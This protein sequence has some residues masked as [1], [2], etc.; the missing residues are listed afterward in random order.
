MIRHTELQDGV[1]IELIQV[2]LQIILLFHQIRL[3]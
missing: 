3:E 1:D 2:I